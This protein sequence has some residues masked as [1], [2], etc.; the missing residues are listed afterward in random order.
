M[1]HVSAA[2][3]GGRWAQ[4]YDLQYR[5]VTVD[6]EAVDTEFVASS[7]LISSFEDYTEEHSMLDIMT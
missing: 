1:T 3:L 4:E 2:S 6:S 5:L 7:L